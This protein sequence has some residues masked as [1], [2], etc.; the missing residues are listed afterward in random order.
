MI[1]SK[2]ADAP[3]KIQ[4]YRLLSAILQDTVLAKSLIFKGG[5]CAALRGWLDRFSVDLDFDLIGVDKQADFRDRLHRHFKVLNLEIKDESKRHLQ[6]FLK[7]DAPSFNR[8]TLKLEINDD[9]SPFGQSE[10][11]TL[12]ELNV[13]ALTQTQSTMVASKMVAALGR[14][15]QHQAIA[16]RD[17]Y[18]L[19]YFLSHGY[20][21]N[22]KIIE[23]RTGSSFAAYCTE[24]TEFITTQVT[25]S[26]LYE[27]LNPLIERIRL[28]KSVR[29]LK[30]ELL[31]L[32]NGLSGMAISH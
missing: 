31:W 1:L 19:H 22:Q 20:E 8:N 24:L 5:T 18:D 25:D 9:V 3:H 27:D 10:I 4:M 7:Y 29:N 16:G 6:F 14:F 32:L 30:T 23:E 11:A 15:K 12:D 13:V 17:F 26:I 21:V 28:K 2:P